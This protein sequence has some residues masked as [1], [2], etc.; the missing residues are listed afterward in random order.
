MKNKAIE[1]LQEKLDR[2]ASETK[3]TTEQLQLEYNKV[4][5]TDGELRKAI[6]ACE[7]S[8][9]YGMDEYGMDEYGEIYS[10]TRFD[11][12][13]YQS[14]RDYLD[15]WLSEQYCVSID[16]QNGAL[17]SRQG[18][19]ITINDCYGRDNG[20]V[21]YEGKIIVNSKQYR[22]SE[23]GE[24]DTGVRNALIEAWMEQHGT[25]PGVFRCTEHGDIFPVNTQAKGE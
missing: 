16:W 3:L 23:T 17:L 7:T 8:N 18:D 20:N 1:T 19:C 15:T 25:F 5:D 12:S 4:F 22:D 6:A 13:D 21:Y 10:R 2:L 24:M 11:T 14:V 9:E